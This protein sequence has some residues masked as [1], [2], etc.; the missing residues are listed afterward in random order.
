MPSRVNKDP[1][2]TG[3]TPTSTPVF[4]PQN[5]APPL[6][7]GRKVH[8]RNLFIPA[9]SNRPLPEGMRS[10]GCLQQKMEKKKGD[11]C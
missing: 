1:L 11:S 10:G 2:L 8:R 6:G 3:L 7:T 5:P 4:R 9:E